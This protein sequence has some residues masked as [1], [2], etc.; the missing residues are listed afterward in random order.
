MQVQ[1]YFINQPD[2]QRTF[3]G[4]ASLQGKIAYYLTTLPTNVDKMQH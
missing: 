3:K 4:E 2:D 1:F